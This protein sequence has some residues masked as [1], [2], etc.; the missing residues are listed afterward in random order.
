MSNPKFGTKQ[1]CKDCDTRF[2]DMKKSPAVCPNCSLEIKAP[3]P[4]KARRPAAEQPA[5]PAPEAPEAPE[6][7]EKKP[8]TAENAGA[9]SGDDK[10]DE[11]LDAL[12]PSDDDSQ[13][14]EVLDDDEDDEELIEDAS[15]LGE[16]DD[17]LHEVR[18][19]I[20]DGSTDKG[21]AG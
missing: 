10:I 12:L 9:K 19:H 5:T 11:E 17:D 16:H 1:I 2:F 20:D 4:A 6:A 21:E 15:D 14:D 3:K 13:D 7:Y 18:E 8:E